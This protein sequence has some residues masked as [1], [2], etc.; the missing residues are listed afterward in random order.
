MAARNGA[1]SLVSLVILL[2]GKIVVL[3]VYV[4]F[5]VTAAPTSNRLAPV[6]LALAVVVLTAAP[7]ALVFT[8][9]FRR[10]QVGVRLGVVLAD[11]AT[12]VTAFSAAYFL[13]SGH[14][15]EIQGIHTR[16]DAVYF[17]SSVLTTVGFGDI[18][19]GGQYARALVTVQM[20]FGFTYL[21]TVLASVGASL[22]S[23]RTREG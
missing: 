14:P 2:V 9:W 7:L 6:A 5:V 22:M 3:A 17:T 12:L 8:R 18:N 4:I 19:A 10:L 11:L 16:I 1:N 23:D 15:G 20:L 21:A 13:L